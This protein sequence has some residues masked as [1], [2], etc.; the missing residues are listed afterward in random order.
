MGYYRCFE[1]VLRLETSK[2]N[3]AE[4]LNGTIYIMPKIDGTNFCA[5]ADDNGNIHCGSRHRE[6]TLEKDNADSMLFFTTEPVFEKLR[7]M[8]ITHPRYIIYGEFIGGMAGRKKVGTIKGYQ[9]NGLW[10]FGMYDTVFCEYLPYPEYK[11]ILVDGNIYSQ[12]IEPL[13]ILEHP[14]IQEVEKY[15]ENHYDLPDDILGEGIVCWNY[16][17]KDEYNKFQIAKIVNAE[18]KVGKGRVKIQQSST[19]NV[20]KLIV[21]A[22]VTDADCEKAKQKACVRFNLEEWEVNKATMGFYL[23]TLYQDLI[24]EELWSIVKKFKQPTIQFGL[25]RQIVFNRG[26]QYLGL[27]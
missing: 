27:I 23:N 19:H 25:L 6:I 21:D 1:H 26:R 9:H 15:I 22:Y 3:V 16:D 17:F 13:A 7:Q 12:V 11:K 10:I 14:S 18:S 2:I 8:L 5:W 24:E 4:F 20:E